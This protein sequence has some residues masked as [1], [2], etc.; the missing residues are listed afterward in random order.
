[1][2]F[3]FLFCK[4]RKRY[5]SWGKT[6]QQKRIRIRVGLA[7]EMNQNLLKKKLNKKIK[8]GR[9]PMIEHVEGGTGPNFTSPKFVFVHE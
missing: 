8:R 6:R 5:F 7:Q 1:M 4:I 3:F 2:T 9:V